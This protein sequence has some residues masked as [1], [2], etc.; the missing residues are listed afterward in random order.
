[1]AM[2]TQATNASRSG[3]TDWLIQRVSA[4]ILALYALF[5]LGYLILQPQLDYS[6]WQ[7]L[8]SY[9]WMRIFSLLSLLALVAHAWV[10][11][12]TIATDYLKPPAL[13]LIVQLI[14]LLA[15]FVYLLWGIEILWGF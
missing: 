10:G 9:N 15:L 5:I 3:L 14:F 4:V 1:M 11:L 13:R 12:W 6:G 8:F 2:V 7:Q